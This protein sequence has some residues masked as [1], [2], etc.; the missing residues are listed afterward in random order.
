MGSFLPPPF[1]KGRK[2]GWLCR[3]VKIGKSSP[4]CLFT[5]DITIFHQEKRMIFQFTPKLEKCIEF[6][7]DLLI[8]F[9]RTGIRERKNIGYLLAINSAKLWQTRANK[10]EGNFPDFSAYFLSCLL[11]FPRRIDEKICKRKNIPPPP[12][13]RRI[14]NSDRWEIADIIRGKKRKG[15]KI[16]FHR[17]KGTKKERSRHCVYYM[18]IFNSNSC[19]RFPERTILI[20]FPF[21]PPKC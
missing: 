4:T 18:E 20:F 13:F 7:P 15:E 17:K 1:G 19:A 11:R 14:K 3:C 8:A 6:F 5:Y 16:L 9:S 10:G 21:A 2:G 12:S